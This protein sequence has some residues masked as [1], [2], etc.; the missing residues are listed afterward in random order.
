[1][2]RPHG[3]SEAQFQALKAAMEAHDVANCKDGPDCALCRLRK[4][5]DEYEALLRAARVK[6]EAVIFH[7]RGRGKA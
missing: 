6:P 7:P 4:R 5:T 1:M 2:K 3:L